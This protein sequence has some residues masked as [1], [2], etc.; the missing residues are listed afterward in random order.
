M[1]QIFEPKNP[2]SRAKIIGE[3]NRNTG[4]GRREGVK[5]QKGVASAPNGSKKPVFKRGDFNE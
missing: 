1:A 5:L 3:S 4:A 2:I